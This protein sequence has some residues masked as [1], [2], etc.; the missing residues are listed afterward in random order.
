MSEAETFYAID[1]DRCLSDTHKLDTV[2]YE[3]VDEQENV[4]GDALRSERKY[5]EDSGG[6]FDEVV[7]LQK[8]IGSSA[9]VDF[10]DTFVERARER[11]MLSDGAR[12]LLDALVANDKLFGIVSYGGE[13]WQR[14]KMRASQVEDIPTLITA[15]KEKG[16]LFRSIQQEDKT[17]LIPAELITTGSP[18]VA[19]SLVFMDDK[20]IAFTDYPT[21]N[22]RGYW[23]QSPSHPLLLSQRGT[24]PDNVRVA[25]GL[26]EVISFESL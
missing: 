6:S 25:Q 21:E 19:Q 11:D 2:F 17:F 7:A 24:V 13:Q 20:A 16:K 4:D 10:F 1:F 15:Q 22:A 18:V 3:V 12:E 26:R 14:I 8:Q 23:V 5:I 9:L